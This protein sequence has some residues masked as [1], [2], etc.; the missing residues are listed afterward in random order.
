MLLVSHL[1]Q[2]QKMISEKLCMCVC[3]R[4]VCVRVCACVCECVSEW[5]RGGVKL[6]K[7]T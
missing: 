4:C 1:S 2:N 6:K 5:V 7:A 3:V